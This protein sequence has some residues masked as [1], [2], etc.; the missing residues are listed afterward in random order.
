MRMKEIF[1]TC[2]C[3]ALLSIDSAVLAQEK[4][5]ASSV[6]LSAGSSTRDQDGLNGPV[7]RVRIE[8][9]KILVKEGKPVES[10]RVLREVT[11]YGPKGEKVDSVAYPVDSNTLT[12]KEQYRYDNNGN[13][14]EMILRAPDGAILSKEKYDYESDEFGNWKK[15]ISSVAVYENG[16]VTYEPVEVTYRTI[17]Y[18]FSD[19]LTKLAAPAGTTAATL[20]PALSDTNLAKPGKPRPDR[21][22]ITAVAQSTV[23]AKEL[24][25][26]ADPEPTPAKKIAET[27]AVSQPANT[28]P[29]PKVEAQKFPVVHV[30]EAVLRKAA[31]ELPEPE[32]PPEIA[33]AQV[34]G[35]VEVQFI[36][37]EK[38]EVAAVR[39]I[40]G[41]PLLMEAA[42]NAGRKARF[43][44]GALSSQPSKIFGILTY[45]FASPKLANKNTVETNSEEPESTTAALRND[46]VPSESTTDLT[47]IEKEPNPAPEENSSK[48]IATSTPQPVDRKAGSLSEN[49]G[50]SLTAHSSA[51]LEKKPSS[52]LEDAGTKPASTSP[53]S[54]S[55]KAA[56]PPFATPFEK[57]MASLLTAKYAAAVEFFNQ[58]IKADSTDA[59]AYCR[60]GLAYS[61][62]EKYKE[63]ITA[64]KQAIR[65]KR[66]FVDADSYYR[67]GTAHLQLNESSAAIE[68]LKQS[69]YMIRAQ[70]LDPDQRKPTPPAPPQA[71]VN[72]AL[73]LAYYGTGAFRNAATEFENAVRLKQDF[74]SAHFGLGLS[75]LAY[76][77]KGSAD[78]EERILRKLKSPLADKLADQIVTPGV[79]K[80]RVF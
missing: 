31:I 79:R 59:L 41:N 33:N 72:Y 68:P 64:Y 22:N 3:L 66:A 49:S 46:K 15:M 10:P 25:K 57:G 32:L 55:A 17:T 29:T 35:N 43:S 6:S 16:S 54:S 12:G 40:S 37:D 77:D 26:A 63:A 28:A 20:T 7:R 5:N 19:A 73:G 24:K 50:N 8:S 70:L 47:A 65:L 67:L 52:S 61:A 76:G 78:K 13:I 21:P 34:E 48:A 4:L 11:T 30:S 27:A 62:L 44:P 23:A 1:L 56:P 42:V 80:N 60:L 14:V 71:E 9:A 69:L 51:P 45:S 39:G 2:I 74:A 58:A 75:H 38:G 18:Y 53:L 36:V